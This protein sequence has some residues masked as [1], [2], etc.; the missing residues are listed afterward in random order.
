MNY[1]EIN[2]ILD[3]N[4]IKYKQDLIKCDISLVNLIKKNNLNLNGIIEIKR[5]NNADDKM[6]QTFCLHNGFLLVLTSDKYLCINYKI[7]HK[8]YEYGGCGTSCRVF[9]YKNIAL[10]IFHNYTEDYYKDLEILDQNLIKFPKRI[11]HS[12]IEYNSSKIH[13]IEE[14]FIKSDKSIPQQDFINKMDTL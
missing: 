14:T 13:I 3:I 9:K 12:F 10:K 6:V 4:K 8:N 11:F 7:E 5:G 2:Q 1:A